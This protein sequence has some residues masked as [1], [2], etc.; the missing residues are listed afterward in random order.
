MVL[1]QLNSH[2]EKVK[3]RTISLTTHKIELQMHQRSNVKKNKNKR[4][5]I[6]EEN[7]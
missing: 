2:F 5:H 1:E 3:I 6:P 7:S 4:I